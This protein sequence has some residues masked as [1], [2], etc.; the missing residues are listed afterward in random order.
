MTPIAFLAVI[1]PNGFRITIATHFCPVQL[2]AHVSA[3]ALQFPKD[4]IAIVAPKGGAR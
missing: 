2:V 4:R 1:T 3:H